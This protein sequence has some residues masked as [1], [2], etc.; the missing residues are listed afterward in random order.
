MVRGD[1]DTFPDHHE[2]HENTFSV[3]KLLTYGPKLTYGEDC[4]LA[5]KGEKEA[6]FVLDLG[7]KKLVNT[8]ELVNTPYNNPQNRSMGEFKVFLSDNSDGPWTQVV[9]QTLEDSRE[10]T[11]PLPVKRF[12]FEEREAHFVRFQQISSYGG[13]GG[14]Q[15]FAVNLSGENKKSSHFTCS[16]LTNVSF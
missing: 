4:W 8:V 16:D 5:P 15:Y 1:H 12:F 10:Q 14:L 13:G 6:E 2:I 11:D 3:S 9:Y 7:C